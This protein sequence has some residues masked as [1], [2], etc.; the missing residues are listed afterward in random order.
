MNTPTPP[1]SSVST[2]APGVVLVHHAAALGDIDEG[3]DGPAEDRPDDDAQHGRRQRHPS[4][5][6]LP[7]ATCVDVRGCG[8]GV[9]SCGKRVGGAGSL[10][11]AAA[12]PD[13]M[14]DASGFSIMPSFHNPASSSKAHPA[15]QLLRN[16]SQ[17]Q[18]ASA[19]VSGIVCW[20]RKQNGKGDASHMHHHHIDGDES[21]TLFMH[22]AC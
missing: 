17:L 2:H 4:P 10:G 3:D 5:A 6:C 20:N 22:P 7:V 16:P 21:I 14:L 11:P 15:S 18:L 1:P 13:A 9:V 8:G 19:P 12:A